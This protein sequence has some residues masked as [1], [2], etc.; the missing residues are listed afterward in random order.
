LESP[1]GDNVKAY[2]DDVVL[3]TM[4]EDNLVADL[5][6][7]FANL[8]RYHWKLNPEKCVFGVPFGKLLDFMVSH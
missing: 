5:T 3:K 2:V 7:T 1:I 4:V 6:Q 8:R